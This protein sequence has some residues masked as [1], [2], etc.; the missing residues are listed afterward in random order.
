MHE[1]SMPT[2]P[3]TVMW[4]RIVD[5]LSF[6]QATLSRLPEGYEIMGAILVAE[7]GKPLR[8]DYRLCCSLDWRTREVDVEQVLSADRSRMSL[9]A[10]GVGGWRVNGVEAP[11]LAGCIDVDLEFSPSTNALP[12]NRLRLKVGERSEI[13]A[14][15]VRFPAL[16]VMT[17]HQAYQRLD[18]GQ[19]LFQS[20]ASGFEAVLDVDRDGLPLLYS[21][22][23][24]RIAAGAAP[25]S[26][27]APAT[28]GAP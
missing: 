27:G 16:H 7:G 19:Y 26:P 15:W 14:A 20:L 6:E 13:S 9:T 25:K 8:I 11:E 1:S 5:D 28:Q 2:L 22:I 23:W 3:R 18:Q 21:G 12:I 4:R 17:S 10:D 24:Q